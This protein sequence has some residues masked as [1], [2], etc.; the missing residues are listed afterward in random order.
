MT[1]NWLYCALAHSSLQSKNTATA[2]INPAVAICY[3]LN[4]LRILN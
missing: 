3:A 4:G 2:G 1:G